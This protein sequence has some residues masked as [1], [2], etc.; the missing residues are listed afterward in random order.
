M[1]QIKNYIIYHSL[2]EYLGKFSDFLQRTQG[3][4]DDA[5]ICE[6]RNKIKELCKKIFSIVKKKAIEMLP[7]CSYQFVEKNNQLTS[8]SVCLCDFEYFDTISML[9]C[10]HYFHTECANKWLEVMPTCPLCRK[11]IRFDQIH[12]KSK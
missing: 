5:S 4:T 1:K 9:P 12:M 10:K 7:V 6:L 8:C 2:A 11:W 3:S